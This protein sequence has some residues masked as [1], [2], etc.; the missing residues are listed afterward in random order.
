MRTT[1]EMRHVSVSVDRSPDDVYRFMANIESMALWAA[2]IGKLTQ[3]QGQDWVS[4]GPLGKAKV[5][6]S[7]PNAFRVLDH[8]V[9]LPSGVTVHN[10]LRVLPNHQGCEVV[11]SVVRQRGMSDD[12]YARDADAVE[13]DLRTLKKLLEAGAA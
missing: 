4:E 2:G 1:S 13:E 7:E 12:E 10:A 5:R 6:F 11:F 3:V 8:D 9:T